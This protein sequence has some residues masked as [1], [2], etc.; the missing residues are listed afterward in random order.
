MVAGGLEFLEEL[1]EA[2]GGDVDLEVV[3]IF[4]ADFLEEEDV[5]DEV[6]VAVEAELEAVS[7]YLV[8]LG[9]ALCEV[10]VVLLPVVGMKGGN[11]KLGAGIVKVDGLPSF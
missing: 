11:A 6:F 1:L 9:E 4:G 5:G 10:G 2:F 3:P 8:G 7:Y